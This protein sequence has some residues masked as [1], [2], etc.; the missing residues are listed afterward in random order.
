MKYLTSSAPLLI[1][2]GPSGTGKSTI[3]QELIETNVI[4]LT[5]TWTDRPRRDGEAEIEHVFVT[6]QVLNKKFKEEYFAHPPIQLFGLPYKYAAPKIPIPKPGKIPSLM[7]RV[8][9]MPLSDRLYPNRIVYQIEAPKKVANARLMERQDLNF[10]TRISDYDKE[11]SQG[12]EFAT[13]IFVNDGD[14]HKVVDEIITAIGNDFPSVN[15]K[16]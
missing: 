7:S 8:M 13:R 4:E 15:T 6:P 2:I 10:G 1:F 12:R 9:A 3:I 16:L 11:I 5:P 14:L